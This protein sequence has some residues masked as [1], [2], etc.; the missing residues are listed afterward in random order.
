MDR[1]IALAAQVFRQVGEAENGEHLPGLHR[2]DV[3]D[4][5]VEIGVVAVRQAGVA[6]SPSTPGLHPCS[7]SPAGQLQVPDRLAI[8]FDGIDRLPGLP[9]RRKQQYLAVPDIPV[10]DPVLAR[11]FHAPRLV[12]AHYFVNALLARHPETG[13]RQ[14]KERFLRLAQSPSHD[15]GKRSLID[16]LRHHANR[17]A[18]GLLLGRKNVV[19]TTI[20]AFDHQHIAGNRLV[21]LVDRRRLDSQVPRIQQAFSGHSAFDEGLRGSQA[22]TGGIKGDGAILEV[23]RLTEGQFHR[24]GPL[25]VIPQQQPR[26]G[27]EHGTPMSRRMVRVGMGDD[28]HVLFAQGIEPKPGLREVYPPVKYHFQTSV[29]TARCGGAEYSTQPRPLPFACPVSLEP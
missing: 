5:V 19:R 24:L 9:A 12:L 10:T 16:P 20:G 13:R 4:Q 17:R 7:R 14:V 6:R 18:D 2:V 3:V 27:R 1:G 22:M 11:K 21:R 29:P 25:E 23:Q 15:H 26:A 28:G 8:R